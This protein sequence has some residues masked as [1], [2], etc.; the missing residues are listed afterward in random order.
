[1]DNQSSDRKIKDLID[2]GNRSKFFDDL[3]AEVTAECRNLGFKDEDATIAKFNQLW[4]PIS[5][6][7]AIAR[8]ELNRTFIQGILGGQGTGK[9]TLCLILKL[10]LNYLGFS[11]ANLSIDDLYLTHQERQ[12]L[13]QQD[14]RLIWRGPPGTHDVNL[15]LQV[16][17]Q[18]LQEDCDLEIL[19]PRFDKS[20]YNGSGDRTTAE[21]I[22]KPDI[23]LFEGWFV[24]V[25]PISEDCFDNCPSPLL[26][27]EDIQFA[28]DNNKLLKTYLPL[29]DKLDRLIV[30]YPQD[31]RLSQQWRKDAERKMMA[32][33]KTGMSD[34]EIDRFVEYFWKSL[35]P[36]LFIKPLRETA[37]LVVEIKSD[38]S[39][40]SIYRNH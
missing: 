39:L 5:L 28:K 22:A 25:R 6:D 36:E 27:L 35:H 38:R 34:E 13:R 14:P 7:L 12:E 30:L 2:K 33:G 23:L 18:C 16:I 19:M 10:I 15:G 29:W 9:S 24:G 17:E 3:L 20:A 21:A 37:D 26:T 40:G 11:V 4:L 1:M 8:N 31:Y 32:S